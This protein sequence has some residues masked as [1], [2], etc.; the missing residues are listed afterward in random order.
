MEVWFSIG[1]PIIVTVIIDCLIFRIAHM[2]AL[3]GDQDSSAKVIIKR[4]TLYILRK[5]TLLQTKRA[6]KTIGQIVGAVL[7]CYLPLVVKWHM[8]DLNSP[9]FSFT[10]QVRI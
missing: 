8:C 1:F 2:E 10:A 9:V 3:R 4:S 5:Y 7:I 6:A